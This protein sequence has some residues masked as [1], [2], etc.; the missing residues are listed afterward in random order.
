MGKILEN[1]N[2]PKLKQ[3]EIEYMNRP[4]TR[5]EIVNC[6]KIFP[7]SRNPGQNGL[8]GEFNQKF[9]K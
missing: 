8:T 7:T 6:Y 9:R 2:L 1:Y 4:I 5:T 3:E